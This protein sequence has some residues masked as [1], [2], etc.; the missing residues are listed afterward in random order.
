MTEQFFFK[1][2]NPEQKKAVDCIDGPLLVMAGAGSGKTRV[3]TY[4]IANLI[5]KGISPWSI[6]AITFTNKA[7]NEMKTRA[8]KLIGEPAKNVVLSTFHSFCARLL[9]REIKIT[10]QFTGNFAI[11]DA[12]DSRST[13]K[14]CVKELDLGEKIFDGVH[15]KISE[16]KNN[17]ITPEKFREKLSYRGGGT[18]EAHLAMIYELYQKKLQINNALD[19]DDLIFKTVQLFRDYP[20]ILDKYQERFKYILIDE[21]QDTNVAQY[22]LTKLLAAKYKNLCVVGDADQSIYGWR[23][24]DMRNILN[25][26][27][28]YPNAKVIILEQ[29][30]RSTKTI[31]KAANAV[32]QN[33]LDRIPKNL[34]T[35]NE[36]GEK[37][38]FI[39]CE[40]DRSEAATVAQEIK[41]LITYENFS[42]NEIALLYRTNAQ[43]RLFE[44]KFMNSE[45]PYV[46]IGGLK[47]YDRKEIKDIL[48][49]LHVIANPHDDLHLLR[50]I[51]TPRRGLGSSNMNRLTEF[52]TAQ[53]LSIM[54]LISD[55][56]LLAQMDFSPRFRAGLQSF[57]AMM[58][59]FTESA[60]NLAV[61]KL[62]NIVLNES[63]Y[64]QMLQDNIKDGKEENISREENL[65]TFVD[66]AKEFLEM[67]PTG[68]LQDF[69][70]HVAL[71]TD[72]DTLDEDEPRVR[73]M[74]VHAAKGL[75]FP[76]VFIVGMEDGIFP[77]V[78]SFDSDEDLEE[79]R[80]ACYVAITR[81]K[82][83]LYITAAEARMSFGKMAYKDISRFVE[84]IPDACVES[85]GIR[86]KPPQRK[87][88]SRS[89]YKPPTAYR[90]A[91]IKPPEN[92]SAQPITLHVG[93]VINHKKWGLGT[94]VEFDK[95][96]ATIAFANPEVGTKKL[97][98]KVAPISII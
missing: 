73:L 93:D 17:L 82:K 54:E 75:E 16:L 55:K 3:L 89:V 57:A 64:M 40:T 86:A 29:N 94:V 13:V 5:A 51:N 72:I 37:I 91:Q 97:V 27:Y 95:G 81:A 6:L 83:K 61:D 98:V 78:M 56:K 58:I 44:E 32:I 65:G 4:R 96:I 49:Y 63:G 50:I 77:H 36:I 11:Y 88:A 46:I 84:E 68:T 8:E 60:K 87:F 12:S 74:T 26:K 31:L 76:V 15:S 59:S 69:L 14:Q 21:Y 71:I 85:F 28:D 47:F 70:N 23:G 33:N 9:R 2:L 22:A 42:Y 34:R 30:Y 35:K 79:E 38:K 20:D 52:A 45:I 90:P 43:S 67:N 24:A 10:N 1:N 53:G 18:Y 48:A 41:R 92:K 19:F 80:R 66:S 25:F 7:A 39:T 62:I